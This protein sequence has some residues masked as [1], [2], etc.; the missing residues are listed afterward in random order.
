[1]ICSE[2]MTEERVSAGTDERST[3]PIRESAD[4][5]SRIRMDENTRE[6]ERR[7]HFHPVVV[8]EL[9]RDVRR[10]PVVRDRAFPAVRLPATTLRPVPVECLRREVP[11][12]P[13][14]LPHSAPPV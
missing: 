5:A 2:P 4:L 3:D 14:A 7:R 10:A 9:R 13:L 11:A 12:A 8:P 1:V 6:G